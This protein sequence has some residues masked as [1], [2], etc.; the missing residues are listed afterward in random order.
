MGIKFKKTTLIALLTFMTLLFII[1]EWILSIVGIFMSEWTSFSFM[2]QNFH[3]GLF[4][5]EKCPAEYAH[6]NYSCLGSLTCNDTEKDSLCDK[7]QLLNKAK[8]VLLVFEGFGTA[9]S[10]L[11][12]E[13]LFYMS[14]R[15]SYGNI[16]VFYAFSIIPAIAKL[17]GIG[18]YII[19]SSTNLS[20]NCN[21]DHEICNEKGPWFLI[22]SSLISWLCAMLT[23]IILKSRDK[24]NEK[25]IK[26][27]LRFGN[28]DSWF[29]IKATPMVL[30]A[31]CFTV[32]G[33]W[34]DWISYHSPN[35][36]YGS[37]MSMNKYEEYS[38]LDYMC[39]S[40]PNCAITPQY[41]NSIR[42][43]NAFHKLGSASY[44]YL[45]INFVSYAFLLIWI[46]HLICLALKIN[47]GIFC[48][49]YFWPIFTTIAN[50][51]GNISWFIVSGASFSS[52][53]RI[54]AGDNDISFCAEQGATLSL[55]G[56]LCFALSS[57]L[58]I[59]I[60]ARKANGTLTEVRPEKIKNRKI[61]DEWQINKAFEEQENSNLFRKMSTLSITRP[62]TQDTVLNG[63][64][65]KS[66]VTFRCS[67]SILD[68]NLA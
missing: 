11:L 49:N 36:I 57:I 18:T 24:S 29:L 26:E 25:K 20:S 31:I 22:E 48:L 7:A 58:Y 67:N 30:L 54:K 56:F 41:T 1:V 6:T 42:D 37:L 21:S 10:L 12:F 45:G 17:I 16:I 8:I 68:R 44:Y 64:F 59:V 51:C 33:H 46:E 63:D 28:Y 2:E 34:W 4:D 32:M 53:C 40:G 5:C 55:A 66:T 39:I 50:L 14:L 3:Y 60:L 38:Q 61:L 27:T 43:C 23:V 13:R 62:N 19:L 9:F 15:K 65:S 47:F 52:T 35:R